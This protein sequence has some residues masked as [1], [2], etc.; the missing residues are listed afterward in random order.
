L[1][2]VAVVAVLL[3]HAWPG[4]FP[5]GFVGVDI[6]FV[7]SGF[8]ITTII[9]GQLNTDHFS[10]ADF[11]VR[12]IRRI[13]PALTVVLLATLAFGWIVLLH[14]EF[15][16]IGKH[17][18]AGAAFVSNLLLW[19]EAGYFDNNAATKPLLHLW[20]LGVEEQFY[21][22]WPLVLWLVYQ[23]KLRFIRVTAL[24]FLISMGANL[25]L[26]SSHPVAAFFSPVTRFWEI[27]AGGM[28]AFLSLH[29]KAM[30]ESGARWLSLGGV[31]LLVLSFAL[32]TPQ[33][34]FPGWWAVLPVGGAFLLIMAGRGGLANRLLGS[35]LLVRIGLIS[36]PLYLWHWPLLAFGFIIYGEKLPMMG[37]VALLA[38][39][40]VL[41]FLTYH[42]IEIPLRARRERMNITW[43]LTA[44]M[45]AIA[46][47]AVAIATGMLR[48]RIDIHGAEQYLAALNDRDFPG[49]T[50]TPIR[51]DGIVF[52][53]AASRA[54]GMTVFL[55]D[56][57][58]EQYGPRIAH[59][60]GS[61]PERYQ[62][63]VFAT[64][65]GCPPIERIIRLPRFRFPLCTKTTEA[66]YALANS[67]NADTVVIGAA[68]YGYFSDNE[69]NLLIDDGKGRLAF[70][71]PRA[72]EL[73]FESL[74]QSLVRLHANGKRVF[75][76]LQPPGGTEFHP[77][78]MYTGS[79][80]AS[81]T[82][83]PIIA[84]LDLKPY[85]QR[86]AVT[87]NRLVAIAKETGATV[88]DPIDYL[89]GDDACP[90]IDEAGDPIYTDSMH[91][92]PAY[93]RRAAVFL[94]QTI[95]PAAG[96]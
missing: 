26:I 72:Q 5:G 32:I 79:R 27:M 54:P 16:Q 36:Y 90:V 45:C 4:W 69:H 29:H 85:R 44:S 66:A 84:P 21:I 8:L 83:R 22:I 49:P 40:F 20:S 43:S 61:N 25:M 62:T 71:A 41:A 77:Q 53:K 47:V 30:F 74:R 6:F 68:W 86:H 10:I 1:R 63:V 9:I 81:I 50:L 73:A 42:F 28:A 60:I 48:E 31:T 67:A 55:G 58:M 33:T 56:S 88:I 39:A 24:I 38:A 11:Y 37:K 17:A 80:F 18:L 82:R 23:R 78:S 3:Y 51:Y 94:D 12:R 92:R 46:L 15:M 34:Q 7:I 57:L 89:C 95:L 59:A 76:I 14:G 75:L 2:A 13:F 52:Q 64:A 35:Q 91:M 65:G 19:H 87:R 96:R 93:S 70:P